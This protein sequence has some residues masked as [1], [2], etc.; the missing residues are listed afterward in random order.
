MT[1]PSP[2][3][4][5]FFA[6]N[7]RFLGTSPTLRTWQVLVVVQKI[8]DHCQIPPIFEGGGT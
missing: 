2:A 7:L 8:A 4:K 6:G 1:G 5:A 3:K